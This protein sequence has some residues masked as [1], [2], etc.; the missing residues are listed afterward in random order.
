MMT[1]IMGFINQHK[2][3]EET[4]WRPVMQKS[5]D[6]VDGL[7]I[8]GECRVC[9]ALWRSPTK[10]LLLIVDKDE[11]DVGATCWLVASGFCC[12]MGQKRENQYG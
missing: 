3:T 9:S 12:E 1:K 7:P 6:I 2:I 11:D 10:M 5:T 4:Q 8:I